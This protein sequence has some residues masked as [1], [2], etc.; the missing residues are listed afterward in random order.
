MT[1]TSR[2]VVTAGPT[3]SADEVRRV[4]PG[5]EVRPPVAADQVLRWRW[6]EADTLIVIDGVFLQSRAVR[7]KELLAL[8]DRGVTV[9]GASS[10]G[11]LRA[12][13]LEA[14]GMHGVGQVFRDY[15]DGV[16]VG[17]DEVALTH[18]DAE[19]AYRP[20]SWALVDLRDAA[21]TAVREGAID[22]MTARTIIE[23]AKSLP[24]TARDE[25]T[26]LAA[27]RQRGC[28]PAALDSFRAHCAAQGPGVKHRDAIAALERAGDQTRTPPTCP[29]DRSPSPSGLRYRGTPV[30]LATTTHLRRWTP[31]PPP[32]AADPEREAPQAETVQACDDE[33]L[34]QLALDWPKYPAF[35]RGVA[36]ECLLLA[37]LPLP[38]GASV[39]DQRRALSGVADIRDHGQAQLPWEPLAHALSLRLT[40]LDLPSSPSQAGPALSL[41]RDTERHQHWEVAGPLL[42]VRTWLGDPRVDFRT[43][44]IE[45]LREHPAYH[46]ALAAL[47]EARADPAPPVND[48]AALRELCQSVLIRWGARERSDIPALLRDHG[49]T[50]IDAMVSALRTHPRKATEVSGTRR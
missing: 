22:E 47:D 46:R 9:Y 7:H 11:A 39:A 49:F 28:R 16:L 45:R 10:M 27:A 23:A 1:H 48:P 33:V 36:A 20:T 15:R 3:I 38:S 29:T 17:D 34:T 24:F 31:A 25:F 35:Q 13:E 40:E 6:D 4:L 32:P 26:V 41:L 50:D 5:A 21:G 2:I 37:T 43:P 8:L 30:R 19:A 42:A 12:A 44:L 14:F 18:A